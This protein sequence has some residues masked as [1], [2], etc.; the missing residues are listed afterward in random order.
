MAVAGGVVASEGPATANV[1][2]VTSSILG[3]DGVTYTATSH[4]T[5]SAVSGPGKYLLVWAGD[6]NA[7]D[8]NSNNSF[9]TDTI[10]HGININDLPQTVDGATVKSDFLA[11]I[12]AEP[13]HT[14]TYG[15][16]VGT[17]TVG[18]IVLN[19]PH[20]MQYIWHQGNKVFAGGLF[21]DIT[22]VFDVSALPI[23]TLTGINLPTSTPCGTVPDAYWV[24]N[25]GTAY[26]TYMGGAD[27][28]GVCTYSN[29]RILASNGFAGSPGEIV[30]LSESGA[31]LAEIPAAPPAGLLGIVP[32]ETAPPIYGNVQSGAPVCTV[33]PAVGSIIPLPFSTCANPHGIQVR[34]DLNR[35]VTSDYAE[36]RNIVL[37]PIQN[38]DANVFRP[39]VRIFDITNRNDPTLVSVSFMPDGP[40][41]ESFGV[42]EEFR[43][44]METTVTNLPGHKGAFAESMCGGAV[45]YTPD[46]TNPNPVWRQVFDNSRAEVPITGSVLYQGG[47]CDGGSWLQTSLDDKYLYHAVMGRPAGSLGAHD[48]GIESMV[49]TLDITNLVNAGTGFTCNIDT[50]AEVLDGGAEADCPTLAGRLIIHDTT[51]GGTHWGAL[52]NFRR[53]ANGTYTEI[54][55]ANNAPVERFATSNYFV[56]RTGRDGNHLV[57]MVN[58]A[59]NGTLAMDNSFRDENTGD[60]CVSFNRLT[61]PHGANGNAKPHSQ[62]F[63]VTS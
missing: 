32:S 28:P 2:V 38:L 11:V 21:S 60:V 3:S 54:T 53:N 49:Y 12:D 16:V 6:A 13:T 22:Y 17:V 48:P 15:K 41:N 33:I 18:P 55:P 40:R 27:V 36:P 52:D 57:C 5:A 45:Y 30:R 62:L 44:M 47:A 7:S 14:A 34:E 9:G 10:L 59:G 50:I 8:A 51:G 19:E 56:A 42:H 31:T 39:T 37:H 35:M 23:V 61:W 58:V 43:G 26:G 4:V 63:V 24:L 1:T 46:I 29:G 20:H 25:D